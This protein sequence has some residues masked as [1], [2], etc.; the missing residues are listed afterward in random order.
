MDYLGKVFL[1]MRFMK[2]HNGGISLIRKHLNQLLK[3]T[4]YQYQVVC[5]FDDASNYLRDKPREEN[6]SFV[7]PGNQIYI[8]FLGVAFTK[9]KA[10]K[11]VIKREECEIKKLSPSGQALLL[12]LIITNDFDCTQEDLAGK[13]YLSEM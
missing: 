2:K 5:I 7:I 4:N 10:L 9:S 1:C 12:E 8:P 3:H 11:Y 13:L 6:I